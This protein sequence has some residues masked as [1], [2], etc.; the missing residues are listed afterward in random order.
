MRMAFSLHTANPGLE[1]GSWAWLLYF[2]PPFRVGADHYLALL[3][4]TD[5]DPSICEPDLTTD[6][7]KVLVGIRLTAAS[8]GGASS[9]EG[10]GWAHGRYA[11]VRFSKNA[12]LV[13]VS[14]RCVAVTE[15]TPGAIVLVVWLGDKG[16]MVRR[17]ARPPD[18]TGYL[19]RCFCCRGCPGWRFPPPDADPTDQFPFFSPAS[20]A[21]QPTS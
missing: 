11:V 17:V 4:V 20:P 13:R 9:V 15:G 14:P 3:H 21:W 18:H 8:P 10:N 19:G 5:V 6:F 7:T 2:N 1:S 12:R 16:I